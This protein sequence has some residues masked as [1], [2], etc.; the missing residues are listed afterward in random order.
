ME[1]PKIYIFFH[2]KARSG[3]W[4]PAMGR[5]EGREKGRESMREI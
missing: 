2:I 5:G 4:I 1:N 3:N